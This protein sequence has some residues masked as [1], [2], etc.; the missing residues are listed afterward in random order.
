MAFLWYT[1]SPKLQL[2]PFFN[3]G[4]LY[5]LSTGIRG[6]VCHINA[7]VFFKVKNKVNR[8]QRIQ[9]LTHLNE[10]GWQINKQIRFSELRF[11]INK[12]KDVMEGIHRLLIFSSTGSLINK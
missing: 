5:Q 1:I 2:K 12:T 9:I 8:N 4:T 10:A 11:H 6:W 3:T 7:L